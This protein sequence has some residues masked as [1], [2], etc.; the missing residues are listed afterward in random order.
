V[1]AAATD[2]RQPGVERTQAAL[3]LRLGRPLESAAVVRPLAT[4]GDADALEQ[5]VTAADALAQS[6][7]WQESLA[8]Y[9][10]ALAIE[11]AHGRAR[12]NRALTQARAGGP[13]DGYDALVAAHPGRADILNDAALC[14]QGRG[15]RETARALFRRAAAL[16]P[17]VAGSQ[18]ARE[19]L[20]ALLLSDRP[21]DAAGALTLLAAVL[22]TEP[23]RDRSLVLRAQAKAALN[24]SAG[25]R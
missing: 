6:F 4:A 13:L 5:L 20:A 21:P 7:R 1:L 19:N 12:S 2:N 24:A 17:D 16:P 9:D 22:D 14:W 10:E 3:L 23:A 15:E 18:D 25:R 8:L 11:P